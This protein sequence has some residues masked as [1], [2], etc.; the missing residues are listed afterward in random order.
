MIE[1]LKKWLLRYRIGKNG[2]SFK[3]FDSNFSQWL[4]EYYR[5]RKASEQGGK[6]R[7]LTIEEEE[8]HGT[9][10]IISNIGAKLGFGSKGKDSEYDEIKSDDNKDDDG[11]HQGTQQQGQTF[12]KVDKVNWNKQ[13]M[14]W[15]KKLED[16]AICIER[17]DTATRAKLW[18]KFDTKGMGK[19]D[20]ERGLMKLLYS[21]MVLYVRTRDRNARPPDIRELQ[22]LLV[23]MCFDVKSMLPAN[24]DAFIL[25]QD[26]VTNIHLYLRKIADKHRPGT[27]DE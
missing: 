19:M 17:T 6:F 27:M 21:L 18:G 8:K 23:D 10:N 11:T 15:E 1:P 4:R 2:L 13:S 7:T 22:P 25:K 20:T 16:I 9:P 5:E 3:D 14:D 26:F 24:N 12:A